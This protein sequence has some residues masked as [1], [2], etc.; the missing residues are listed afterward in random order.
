MNASPYATRR[1]FKSAL[2]SQDIIRELVQIMCLSELLDPSEE[3]WFVSPWISDVELLDNRS[4]GFDAVNPQWRGR[5]IRLVDLALQMMTAGSRVVIVTRG[6]EH[7]RFF[8]DKLGDRSGEAGLSAFLE[9][10]IS[11]ALHTK[12]ILTKAGLLSGSMNLTYSGL[13][14]NDESVQYDTAPD[15][16]E[17]ARLAFQLYR[18]EGSQ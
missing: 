12:G 8:L 6:D 14:L 13:E 9:V 1:I 3:I 18:L 11:E 15:V 17:R 2:T 4:G 10:L 16:I 5:Q 7:N